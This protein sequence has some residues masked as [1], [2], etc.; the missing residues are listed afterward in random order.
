MNTSL[1]SGVLP[2]VVT[3]FDERGQFAARPFE[4]LLERLYQSDVHGVYV[5]GQTGEGLQQG[6]ESRKQAAEVAVRCSPRGK[7]VVIHVG[8]HRVDE[9]VELARHAARTGAHAVSS[10]PPMG[11]YSYRECKSYYETLASASDLPLLVYFFPEVSASISTTDQI[12][13]LCSIPN[14]VGLKFTDYDLY[15]ME[16]IKRYNLTVLN[17]RDE[18]FAAGL[19]MGAD[20][21][22]GSF[23]NLVPEW[24]LEVFTLAGRD[25]WTSA[26][27]VQVRI[28]ELVRAVLD[29][30][31]FPAI[32]LILSWTGVDCGH[33][34]APRLSL[35][36]AQ[37]AALRARLA[38]HGLLDVL[39]VAPQAV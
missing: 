14:V 39:R 13:D 16:S 15:K 26:R 22:I 32:K 10:L 12:L 21:G 23:Y 27:A 4:K 3:P 35:D 1:L 17:G 34:L 29:F 18:V 30:P 25:E 2:A 37:Q 6:T 38:D 9:A 24:F 31:V 19:L 20:G 11:G 5:C 7:Q 33:C 28:N 8:A 36:S